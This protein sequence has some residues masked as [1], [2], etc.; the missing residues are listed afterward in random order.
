MNITD[1]SATPVS[2]Y[3]ASKG[4]LTLGAKVGIAVGAVIFLLATAGFC[5]VCFGRRR[6]RR[7]LAAHQRKTGYSDWLAEQQARNPDQPPSMSGG[8]MS[9][10]GFYDSPS[11]QRPL[12][13]PQGWGH[14]ALREDESPAGHVGEKVYFSP[15]SSQYSSPVSAS[16]QV[17]GVSREWPL[18]RKGAVPGSMP[19]LARSKSTEHKVV[20]PEGD[21]IEMQNVAPVL[22]HPGNGRGR[23]LTE[24]DARRGHAL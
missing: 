3:N 4:G 12:F 8:D 21:R 20:K 1:P 7:A 14:V 6:R 17:H 18:D 23:I 5:I 24:E 15:Y 10:G 16:D 19:G 13:Q 22:L 2:S 11:S 9:A